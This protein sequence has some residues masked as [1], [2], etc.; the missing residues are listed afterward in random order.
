MRK[1]AESKQSKRAALRMATDVFITWRP[2]TTKGIG[3]STE[4]VMRNFSMEG[5]YIE[6]HRPV[7][8]GTIVVMRILHYPPASLDRTGEHL[9]RSICLAEVMWQ[10][11]LTKHKTVWYGTG[12][13]YL[14]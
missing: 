5:V 3:R 13:R 11:V 4:G 8:P 7:Q 12:L 9:P 10:H 14:K 1:N 6:T 2:H